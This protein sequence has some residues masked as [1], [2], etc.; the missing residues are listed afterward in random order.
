[1]NLV[2]RSLSVL[3]SPGQTTSAASI[4]CYAAM[5][6]KKPLNRLMGSERPR[7][8][9]DPPYNVRVRDIGGRGEV[10]TKNCHGP[11]DVIRSPVFSDTL[12]RGRFDRRCPAFVCMDWRHIGELVEAGRVVSGLLN[13]IAG[14]IERRPGQLY[15]SQ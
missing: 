6:A 1:M 3:R 10:N 15:R 11:G 2:R 14:E 5:R 12:A 9:F 7:G 4:A 13:L 8:V